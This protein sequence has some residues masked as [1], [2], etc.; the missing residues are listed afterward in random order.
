MGVCVG[1]GETLLLCQDC[2]AVNKIALQT[3]EIIE[4]DKRIWGESQTVELLPCKRED[5]VSESL[6]SRQT[7]GGGRLA[8]ILALVRQT[9][10]SL[11]L[12]GQAV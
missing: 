5:T 12:S 8:A 7:L 9:G 6:H 11:E 2:L 3:D 1:Q 10:G 4:K